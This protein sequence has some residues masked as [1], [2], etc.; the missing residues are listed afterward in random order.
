MTTQPVPQLPPANLPVVLRI[1][2]HSPILPDVD[3]KTGIQQATI[4]WMVETQHPFQPTHVVGRIYVQLGIGV[5]IYS[6][7][8]AE[9]KDEKVRATYVRDTIPWS[10][11]R[12]I[13]EVMDAATFVEEVQVAESGDPEDPSQPA[14]NAQPGAPVAANVNGEAS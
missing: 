8:K 4:L 14:P 2:T 13:E 6:M 10:W 3:P 9:T 1:W 7:P 11:V 5:E 12:M